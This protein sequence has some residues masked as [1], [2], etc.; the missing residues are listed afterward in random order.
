VPERDPEVLR[1]FLERL[2]SAIASLA[3]P[4]AWRTLAE[5]VPP[6][7]GILA[8]VSSDLEASARGV[9]AFLNLE[10]APSVDAATVVGVWRLPE[11]LGVSIDVHG[12]SWRLVVPVDPA[13]GNGKDGPGWTS[14]RFGPFLVEI[15]LDGRPREKD[16]QEQ[17][18]AG[19]FALFDLR[20]TRADVVRVSFWQGRRATM[21]TTGR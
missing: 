8:R 7:A 13:A 5:G 9:C 15:A 4:G 20:R 10:S 18:R 19:A 3:G 12:A 2:P 16:G 17:V 21:D 6:G 14:L 1:A 11:A